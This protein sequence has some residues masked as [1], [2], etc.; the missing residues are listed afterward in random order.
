MVHKLRVSIKKTRACIALARHLSGDAF[1]GSRYVRLLKVLH[2]AV[3][4]TRDLDLQQQ[5]LRRYIEQNPQYFRILYLLLKSHQ[6]AA[7]QQA[8]NIAAAFP[9]RFIKALPAQLLKKQPQ[10]NNISLLQLK[11]Y[12]QEEFA[13]IAAPRGTVPAEQWHDVRKAVK[14]LYYHLEMT[15]PLLGP[16]G[17]AKRIMDFANKTGSQLGT[18][19]DLVA[20][21]QF[22]S[23][24]TRLMKNIGVTVPKG[25]TTLCRRITVDIRKELQQCRS[26][27]R[28]KPDV[29][30]I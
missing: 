11:A 20:F 28:Q 7:E 12:L 26:L 9:V 22:V 23:D 25:A 17:P 14:R 29:S 21:R 5:H 15:E 30:L 16:A 2:L 24:S 13:A 4:A 3:G 10:E 19:H 6:Q 8:Q 27:L 18:W 1:R